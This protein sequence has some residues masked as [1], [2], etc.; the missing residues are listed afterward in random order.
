M[1]RN[2]NNLSDP[3]TE[4][5]VNNWTM[6]NQSSKKMIKKVQKLKADRSN[7]YSGQIKYNFFVVEKLDGS[8][9]TL[10]FYRELLENGF[11]FQLN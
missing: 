7:D 11:Q 8:Y 9:F 3:V 1:E 2:K 10:K 4:I 6:I 5:D